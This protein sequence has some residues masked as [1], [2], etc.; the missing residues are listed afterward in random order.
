VFDQSDNTFYIQV[1][2]GVNETAAIEFRVYKNFPN[3]FNG[4]TTI[5]FTIPRADKVAVEIFNVAGQ[6]VET[7]VDGYLKGGLHTLTWD[8]SQFSAGLYFYHITT[9]SYRHTAKMLVVK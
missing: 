4:A 1:V 9:G 6:K 7:I 5:A 2:P 8:A 3:P